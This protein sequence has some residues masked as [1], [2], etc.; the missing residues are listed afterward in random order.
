MPSNLSCMDECEG[1]EI[2]AFA[3][4][5]AFERWLAEHHGRQEGVWVKVAKK[6]SG[7]PSVTDDEL[8]DHGL[9]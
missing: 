4:G 2:V 5:P 1:V 3:D 7:I 6:K 9:C 8:V